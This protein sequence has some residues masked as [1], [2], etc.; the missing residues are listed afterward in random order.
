M[1]VI[2]DDE[3]TLFYR[4]WALEYTY[5]NREFSAIRHK[6][7][8]IEKKLNVDISIIQKEIEEISNIPLASEEMLAMLEDGFE[9]Y[10]WTREQAS[11][12][13]DFY[14]DRHKSQHY[15]NLEISKKKFD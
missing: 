15:N 6:I 3:R 9:K 13:H 7:V 1:G 2:T 10:P 4:L 14:Y 5:R 11:F 8:Q 12:F